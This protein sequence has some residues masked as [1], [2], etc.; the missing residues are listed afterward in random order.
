MN[1]GRSRV[2]VPTASPVRV[3]VP[4]AVIHLRIEC[5][6]RISDGHCGLDVPCRASTG[7]DH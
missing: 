3:A 1:E 5:D 2:R 6:E 4:S 7:E